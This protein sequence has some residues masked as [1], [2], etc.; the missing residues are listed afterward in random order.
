[1]E[2]Q[3]IFELLGNEFRR[4]RLALNNLADTLLHLHETPSIFIKP[5]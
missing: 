3:A 2:H 4:V 1:M 5:T